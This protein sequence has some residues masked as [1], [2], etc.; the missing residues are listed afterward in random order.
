MKAIRIFL[1]IF[2]SLIP[3]F[4]LAVETETV[5]AA[6]YTW[7]ETTWDMD[8]IYT[9]VDLLN[10]TGGIGFSEGY[11]KV[12]N[13]IGDINLET[14]DYYGNY[15]GILLWASHGIYDQGLYCVITESFTSETAAT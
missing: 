3:S 2:I 12:A 8:D 4:L 14:I 7:I 13:N 1:V 9:Q 5:G 6:T 15:G 11:E 10:D